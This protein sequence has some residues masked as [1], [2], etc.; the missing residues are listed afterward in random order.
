MTLKDIANLIPTANSLALVSHNLK[1]AK[2]KKKNS[3]DLVGLG[4]TNIIGVDLIKIQA[5]IIGGL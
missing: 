5:D 4:V 3:K 2:K 1:V